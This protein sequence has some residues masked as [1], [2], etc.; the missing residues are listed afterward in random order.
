MHGKVITTRGKTS[1]FFGLVILSTILGVV[2]FSKQTNAEVIDANETPLGTIGEY[3]NAAY[4]IQCASFFT[5]STTASILDYQIYAQSAATTTQQF[6]IDFYLSDDTRLPKTWLGSTSIL[7]S[8]ASTTAYT[9]LDF[10]ITLNTVANQQ[11][12][13]KLSA[14]TSS[15]VWKANLTATPYRNYLISLNGGT[16]WLPGGTTGDY[17]MLFRTRSD[18]GT[19]AHNLSFTFPEQDERYLSPNSYSGTCDDSYTPL[20]MQIIPEPCYWGATSSSTIPIECDTVDYIVSPISCI[21]DTWQYSGIELDPGR[22]EAKISDSGYATTTVQYFIMDTQGRIGAPWERRTGI[23]TLECADVVAWSCD[24]PLLGDICYWGGTIVNSTSCFVYRT[25][26]V[27]IEQT[28]DLKPL[29]YAFDLYD[30]A[31]LGLEATTTTTTISLNVPG[32]GP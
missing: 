25:V 3:C 13:I 22:Y 31:K 8:T 29:S 20:H 1:L 12:F 17:N 7:S 6:I 15:L 9:W 11:Y 23:P 24:L 2:L 5:A 4:E 32:F 18:T 26:V 30:A 27:N 21:A 19:L 10:P 14:P 16:S 28:T